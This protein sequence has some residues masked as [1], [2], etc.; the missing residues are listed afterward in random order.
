LA[1]EMLE[2]H[3]ELVRPFFKRHRGREIKTIDDAF[4]VE[5]ASALEAVRCAFEVQQSM[6]ESNA[7]RSPKSRT[8]LRI[9]IHLGDVVLS[10]GDI[11]GDA[12]NV[13]SRIETIAEPGG[14]C[15]SGQVYDQV[16]NKFEFPIVSLGRHGLKNVQQPVR[17]YKIGLP[18]GI[19]GRNPRIYP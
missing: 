2:K 1:L 3:R 7:T 19:K 18:L 11:Y 16:R 15:I 4:L 9:G 6:H 10:A 13:A 14:I 5:I 8:L 12:V 17:V